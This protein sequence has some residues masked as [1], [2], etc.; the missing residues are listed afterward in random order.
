MFTTAFKQPRGIDVEKSY[1]QKAAL[2][3]GALR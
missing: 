2:A 3:A 1:G